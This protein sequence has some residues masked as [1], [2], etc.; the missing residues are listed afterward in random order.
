[1]PTAAGSL[2]TAARHQGRRPTLRTHPGHP[3]GKSDRAGDLGRP[4]VL[5]GW[6][7]AALFANTEHDVAAAVA[8]GKGP[9][10]ELNNG[11]GAPQNGDPS[12][13][14]PRHRVAS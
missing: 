10:T 12:M 7:A 14:D 3:L 5:R 8:S 4:A 2:R 1:M 11:R 9:A 6:E 13:Q